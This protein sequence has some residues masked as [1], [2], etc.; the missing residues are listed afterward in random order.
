LAEA[1]ALQFRA[2]Y[3]E[4][5]ATEMKKMYFLPVNVKLPEWN[6]WYDGLS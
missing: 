6:F 4:M 3:L 2:A 1:T 5:I